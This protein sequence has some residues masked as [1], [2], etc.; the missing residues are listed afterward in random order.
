[1]SDEVVASSED[2]AREP[3]STRAEARDL[4]DVTG[5]TLRGA[6]DLGGIPGPMPHAGSATVHETVG[7][8]GDGVDYYRFTV[9]EACELRVG[10]VNLADEAVVYLEDASGRCCRVR[11]RWEGTRW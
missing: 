3:G 7:G 10:L 1:M 9:S 5:R 4:G 11:W 2:E 8:D 6:R